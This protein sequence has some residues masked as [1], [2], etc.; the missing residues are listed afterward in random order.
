M[1][2]AGV[3]GRDDLGVLERLDEPRR[4]VAEVA[5]GRRREDDHAPI[6]RPAVHD[7]VTVDELTGS[8]L[9]DGWG[10]SMLRP[11]GAPLVLGRGRRRRAHRAVLRFWNLGHPHEIVFDETY[12]VKDAW[13]L[14]HLGYES[15]WPGRR[16][17]LRRRRHRRSFSTIRPSSCIR[18]SASG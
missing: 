2:G 5:D 3:L 7:R 4:R 16:R 10:R 14:L 1:R 15:T 8:R 9:D 18:R 6:S 12:Y 11:D 17:G 13:T